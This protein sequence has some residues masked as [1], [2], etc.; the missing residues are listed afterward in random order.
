MLS[1]P[2]LLSRSTQIALELLGSEIAQARRERGWS[3]ESL[4]RR[5]SVSPVTVRSVERG[6]PGAAVGTVFEL[7]AL[8]GVPLFS[9]DPAELPR[10]LANSRDRLSLLPKRVRKPAPVVDDEF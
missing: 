2:H 9:P 6:A 5:A 3:V 1:M 8:T 10:M 7:A 4:A